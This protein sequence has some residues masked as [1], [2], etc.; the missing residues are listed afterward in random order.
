MQTCTNMRAGCERREFTVIARCFDGAL[1]DDA[2]RFITNV[3]D[4]ALTQINPGPRASNGD[5][6][7]GE[8]EEDD[9]EESPSTSRKADVEAADF[10]LIE[11]ADRG[12]GHADDDDAGSD[13]EHE[14][15]G[16][17]ERICVGC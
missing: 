8:K 17:Y 3:D 1:I 10:S 4:L 5:R 2:A 15:A 9:E 14:E 7:V 11:S 16:G 6:E 13:G 12:E